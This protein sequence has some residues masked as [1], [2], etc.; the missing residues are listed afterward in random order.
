MVV[1]S[2]AKPSPDG[3]SV[4]CAGHSRAAFTFDPASVSASLAKYLGTFAKHDDRLGVTHFL[5]TDTS[6][7]LDRLAIAAWVEDPKTHKVVAAAFAPIGSPAQK[8]AR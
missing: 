8:A 4:A 2:I 1:R 7:P 5:M 6:L 3:F